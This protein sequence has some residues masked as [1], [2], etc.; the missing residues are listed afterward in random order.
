MRE[1][2][3]TLIAE[4]TVFFFFFCVQKH[5]NAASVPGCASLLKHICQR[6][7]LICGR[8]SCF[9]AVVQ[10]F[11]LPIAAWSWEI[12]M[13]ANIALQPSW[14]GGRRAVWL[15][16]HKSKETLS[17]NCQ[18]ISSSWQSVCGHY[19]R[20]ALLL[21]VRGSSLGDSSEATKTRP[22]TGR[23]YYYKYLN[24]GGGWNFSHLQYIQ[25]VGGSNLFNICQQLQ[26]ITVKIP[27]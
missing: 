3:P 11:N 25:C 10:S 8:P 27:W 21:A 24:S 1:V 12:L 14:A 4:A 20:K 18:G 7:E 6:G 13:R 16:Y 23:L 26:Y 17:N 15:G 2:N 5:W 19:V 22:N 9:L